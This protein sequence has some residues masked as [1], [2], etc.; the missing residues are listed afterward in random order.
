MAAEATAEQKAFKDQLSKESLEIFNEA[1][2]Q[3]FSQQ[4]VFFLNAF[5]HEYGV[6]HAEYIYSVV[7]QIF[8]M[9]D[10]NAK[11]VQYIHQYEEGDDLDFDM[12]LYVFEHLC[13]QAEEPTHNKFRPYG[14]HEWFK[15]NP[16]FVTEHK[17]AIPESMS[18]QPRKIQLRDKVDVNFDGRVSMLE[19]LLYQFKASPKELMARSMNASEEHEEIRKAR[20]ALAEVRKRVQAYEAEKFRLEEGAKQAGVKG[21]K[22]KNE[23]A[24]LNSSPLWEAINKALITAE[25]QVRIA[26]RKFAPGTKANLGTDEAKAGGAEVVDTSMRTDGAIWWMNRELEEQKAKYGSTKKK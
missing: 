14:L 5:W 6:K 20:L 3:P 9:A 26:T 10:M 7:N 12:G 13:L 8:R 15:K 11:G 4:C 25:A 19:F 1:A 21:L 17:E 2:K 24:Q 23:L 18:A 22:F 16:N